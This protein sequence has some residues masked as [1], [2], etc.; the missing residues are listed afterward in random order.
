MS[1]EQEIKAIQM[2]VKEG[3]YAE[4][5]ECVNN[6]DKAKILLRDQLHG[7]EERRHEFQNLEWLAKFQPFEIREPNH[8]GF[9][10]EILNY[11]RSEA[12]SQVITLDSK[13]IES[14]NLNY[15]VEDFMYERTYYSKINLNKLGKS[16]NFTL[17][18]DFTGLSDEELMSVIA[19]T[20]EK[21]NP[22]KSMYS[23]LMLPFKTMAKDKLS[24]DIGSISR[25]SNK[26]VWD[27][28]ALINELGEEFIL[29]HGKV[30][31][32]AIDE[33]ILLGVLPKNIRSEYQQVVDIRLEFEVMSL[34]AER[35]ALQVFK[36]RFVRKAV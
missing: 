5:Q 20:S 26:P 29:K 21:A 14:N 23:E 7:T 17:G 28:N 4:K 1:L 6:I 10:E 2:F 12:L 22:L 32:S 3:S 15:I 27:I 11:V 13:L 34:E 8:S 36:G 9:I 33:W 25:V 19:N 18:E 30:K 24:L 31:L 16:F 35:N